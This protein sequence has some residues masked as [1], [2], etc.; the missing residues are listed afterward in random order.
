MKKIGSFI[1]RYWV[2][3]IPLLAALPGINAFP[4]SS[5]ESPYTDLAIGHFPNAY[6]VQETIKAY[7]VIPLWSPQ[8]FSGFP[9]AAHPLSHIWYP[10]GWA[11]LLFPL[12]LGFN[13]VYLAHLLLGGAGMYLLLR[14]SGLGHPTGLLG[15]FLFEALPRH[16]AFWGNGHLTT[17]YGM[18]WLPWIFAAAFESPSFGRKWKFL[19]P[20]VVLGMIF[21]AYPPGALYG[22]AAWVVWEFARRGRNL[23]AWGRRVGIQTLQAVLLASPLAVPMWEYTQLSTRSQMT[24]GDILVYSLPPAK[25]LGLLFPDYG[26][27]PEGLAYFGVVVF[28]LFLVG[29]LARKAPPFWT[30]LA[31]ASLVFSLG[32]HIPGMQLLAGLPGFSLLRV[33]SRAMF[34][35][36]FAGAVAAAYSIEYLQGFV[37]EKV[38]RRLRMVFIGL[39]GFVIF[40]ALGVSLLTGKAAVEFLMGA[41]WISLFSMLLV[42]VLRGSISQQAW[43]GALLILAAAD[44]GSMTASS[45]VSRPVDQVLAEGGQAAGFIASQPG[46][47]RVYSPSYS[48]PQ[49]TAA[50]FGIELADGVDPL[51]LKSYSQY[52]DA[53]SGVPREKYSITLPP[54]E[55]QGEIGELNAGYVPDAK[56]L[57][58]LNVRFIAAEFDIQAEGLV[59]REQFGQTRIYENMDA[60]P[61]AW[62]ERADG[63]VDLV[64]QVDIYP[65]KVKL[66]ADGPGK[67][68]LSEIAYPGWQ[69]R[70]AEKKAEIGTDGLLRTVDIGAGRQEI[71]FRFFPRSV[72]AGIALGLTGIGLALW[73]GRKEQ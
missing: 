34:L 28:G 31:A 44:L 7:G 68:T 12:P 33:P 23:I 4:F 3:L 19:S 42:V 58:R 46:V 14:R 20:G 21:L 70:V 37:D 55:G 49:Q 18:M 59:L 47:F 39:A 30:W 45:Y 27:H 6:Y 10:G 73:A 40:F 72:Y 17:I 15:A 2:L 8:L 48:I 29:L 36:G 67:L 61:R 65:N 26:A 71:I 50:V 60:M 9:L 43:M 11:A 32:E 63:Q 56:L 52:F 22:G 66:S 35:T 64:D 25:L 16:F 62:V 41:V 53:A 38:K 5:A 13:L 24:A 51:H 54:F 69:V 1:Q 57:G